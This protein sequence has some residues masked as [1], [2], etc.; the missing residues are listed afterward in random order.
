MEHSAI[1]QIFLI[2]RRPVNINHPKITE[3][4]QKDFTDFSNLASIFPEID[5]CFFCLGV[6]AIGKS[7]DEYSKIT[8]DIT[9]SLARQLSAANTNAIFCFVSGAGTDINGR[10]MWAR[11]KARTELDLKKLP[12]RKV[13]WFRP[14]FIQ[15]LKGIKSAT[16]WYN[17]FYTLLGPFTPLLRSI[18]PHAITNTIRVGLAMIACLELNDH[19]EI[20]ENRDINQLANQFS[21]EA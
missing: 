21:N 15:P 19:P 16:G 20:L 1:D 13:V 11:V 5:G 18:A 10:A 4:I 7:E 6:S 3:I 17:F 14:G 2:N 9:L 12:F 8:Y